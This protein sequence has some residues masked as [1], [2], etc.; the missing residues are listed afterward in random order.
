MIAFEINHYLKRKTQGKV[1]YVALK[2]DMSKAYD[3]V[4]WESLKAIMTKMGLCEKWLNLVW[5]VFLLKIT[6]FLLMF[7][8]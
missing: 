2:L 4:A 3:H 8:N 6:T 1:D 7:M 5:G